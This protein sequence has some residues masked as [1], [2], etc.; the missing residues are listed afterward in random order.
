MQ[1]HLTL[2][3]AWEQPLFGKLLEEETSGAR[4]C[5]ERRGCRRAG[6]GHPPG[7]GGAGSQDRQRSPGSGVGHPGC[8][9]LG[10][11]LAALAW[12][13]N[14]QPLPSPAGTAAAP[15]F[16]CWR[17]CGSRSF[18]CS[19]PPHGPAGNTSYLLTLCYVTPRMC[20]H[21][22]AGART[23][24]TLK[25][26]HVYVLT[27]ATA[28]VEARWGDRVHRTPNLTLYLDKAVKPDPPPAGMPF[29]KTGGQLWLRVPGSLCQ[30]GGWPLQWEARF[31]RTG[32]HSWTQVMCETVTDK[33]GSVTCTLGGAG[34]FEVQLRYKP[35]HWSSYWSDWSS[36]IFIPEEILASPALSYQLGKLGTDGQRVLRLRWQRAPKE[37]GDVNYTLHARMLACHCTEPAEEEPVVL[38]REVTAHNLTL[39]GAEYEILLTVANAAGTGPAQQ[40][41]VPAELR[42][43]TCPAEGP[44]IP[45]TSHFI[46]DLGFKDISVSGGTVSVWWEAPSPGFVYCFERQLL[47]G[48]LKQGFC[49][50]RD[51]PAK[52]IHVERGALE[53]PACYRL[54]VHGWDPA[55]G[56]STFA[57]QHHY[58]SNAS[59][60]VPIRINA[61]AEDA[62]VLWWTPSSRAACPGALAKYLICHVAE[63]DNVT[64][65]EADAAA[66]RYTLQNLRPGTAYRVGVWEV[67][68]ESGGT[69]SAWRHFQTKALGNGPQGAAPKSNLKYLGIS[70]SLPAMATIYQ[71]SK[72]RA[73]RL[74]F[75]PL[76]KPVGSKAI[77]FSAS[78][79]SQGQPRPGFVEP[80]ESF[81]PAELLL[82][83]LNPGKEMTDTGTQPGT[84]QPSPVAEE[85]AVACPAGCEKELSFAYRRQDMLSPAGFP[86][87]G[88]TSCSSCL[89]S[90]EE[91]ENKDEEEDEE[92][93][94]QELRQLPVAIA[95][96]ISNKPI[97]IRDEEGWDPSLENRCCSHR[98]AR[99]AGM[100]G[101]RG[102]RGDPMGC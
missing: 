98:Q 71:L 95:L 33:D 4:S 13:G 3:P 25:H 39:S 37:Q 32:D 102:T 77:Q 73:R 80:S 38:G 72:K 45:R 48:A 84:L 83:E 64:Y 46:P 28:W 88:S 81:S 8:L 2:C 11:L 96:L 60:A 26:Q 1:S 79:M 19:W 14:H 47:P 44:T 23:T 68:A 65:S 22:E 6:G 24:Y 51:F 86:P 69:C 82:T 75:P 93:G 97:I 99:A 101:R 55:R 34:A 43:G 61:S 40:L 63:G 74:L 49:I 27:N 91:E 29:T 54:A 18:L 92:E 16:S 85:P 35:P 9:M 31:Q 15:G 100:D 52:S 5:T 21:F 41:R 90:E 56:W 58:A 42:A 10:W 67:T 89:A 20:Q 59:L 62:A 94:R 53:V 70:L 78:E 7:A 30:R 12:G 17:Q 57:L 66:S 50:Q 76:P 36:S 87:P